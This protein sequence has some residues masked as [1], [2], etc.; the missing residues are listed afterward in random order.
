MATFTHNIICERCGKPDAIVDE[1][2]YVIHRLCTSCVMGDKYA[3]YVRTAKRILYP[4]G[5]PY[6]EPDEVEAQYPDC[7]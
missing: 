4:D 1:K 7:P 5:E 2:P 6:P 3:S